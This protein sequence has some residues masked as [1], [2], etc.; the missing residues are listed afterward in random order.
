[1][2]TAVNHA[3]LTGVNV[4]DV[5]S[6]GLLVCAPSTALRAVAGMM[7]VHEVHAVALSDASAGRPAVV[8]DLDLVGAATAI[9][10]ADAAAVASAPVTVAPSDPLM[11]AAAAMAEQG[12]SHVLVLESG[13]AHPVGMLSTL[14]IAAAL[15]GRDARLTRTPR[16]G[17]PA[18]GTSRLDRVAVARAMHLGVFACPPDAS[19][20]EVAAIL[21]DRR[22]H[23]VAVA[24][25][26]APASWKFITDVSV[27][28]AAAKGRDVRAADL[29]GEAT[30]IAGEAALDEA[31]ALMAGTGTSHLLVLGRHEPVGVLST[32]DVINV[33]AVAV[34]VG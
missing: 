27:A 5:M 13:S 22:V 26:P 33:L 21:V 29:V 16:P 17:R 10:M 3:S 8:T 14:D 4:A 15:A 23:C 19:L 6:P 20:R 12:R 25:T 11:A 24:V 2:S 18:I 32:L 30:W 7:V 1:M 28:R 34:G 9:E 31:T